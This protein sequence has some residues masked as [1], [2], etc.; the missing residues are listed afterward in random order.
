MDME[1]LMAMPADGSQSV[2]HQIFDSVLDAARWKEPC[3][4]KTR[5]PFC[6]NRALLARKGAVDN[7]VSLLYYYE[8]ASGKRWTFRDLFSLISHVLVGDASELSIKGRAFTPCEWAAEQLKLHEHG[9]AHSAE[10]DRSLYLLTSRLYY[11]RLFPRWPSLDTGDYRTAKQE[12]LRDNQI[13][14]GLAAAKAFFRYMAKTQE[15][16]AQATGDVPN[17]IRKSFGAAIEPALATGPHPL[18]QRDSEDVTVDDIEH[19]FSLS[20][21]E[22]LTLC[23]GQLETLEK[24]LLEGLSRADSSLAD[25]AF[26]GAR[27]RQARLLR[28]AIRQF[29]ARL[30]KRSLC[31]RKGVCRDVDHYRAYVSAIANADELNEARRQL[32]SLL[33]DRH[34]KFRAP[35]ATTFGQPVAER[36]RDV[37]LI[38][39]RMIAVHPVRRSAG[40]KRPPDPTPFFLAEHHPIA[41]TF[42]LF[43]AL[44]DVANGMHAASLPTDIYSLLDRIKSLVAGDV[45]RDPDLLDS[46]PRIVLGSSGDAVDYVNDGFHYSHGDT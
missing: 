18:F 22:G 4:L 6:R 25:D 23:G 12:L 28:A 1:S 15:L 26:T 36:S 9:P 41:I 42:D 33:H 5:C 7:L 11:H 16:A 37:S 3:A 14:P 10:R 40:D 38:L 31:V 20:V 35:L 43:R 34:N 32:R 27:T 19:H 8:L 30:V 13:N 44:R 24:N 29:S 17:L 2:A 39:P 21:S 45:A 46:E